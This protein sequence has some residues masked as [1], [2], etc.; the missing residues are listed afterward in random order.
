MKIFYTI[1]LL[2]STTLSVIAQKALVPYRVGKL[3]GLSDEK[4]NI[5][6]APAYDQ[7]YWLSGSWFRAGKKIELKDTLE[8]AP[9][10]F[11]IRNNPVTV[12]SLMYNGKMVLKDEPFDDVELIAGK[13]IAAKYEGRGTDLTKENFKKYGNTRKFYSLFNLEGK[14]LHPENF[15]SIRKMDTTGVSTRYKNQ[16]RYILFWVISL[17]NKQGLLV[18]DADRQ[19]ISE[20]LV[21]DAHQMEPDR[22]RTTPGQ[23]LLYVTDSNGVS[24]QQMLDYREGK[25]VLQPAPSAMYPG[26]TRKENVNGREIYAGSGSGNG[27]GRMDIETV[28]AEPG[29]EDRPPRPAPKFKPYHTF[30]R[31]S[32]YY[33]TS[34]QRQVPVQLP[35][36]ARIIRMV[37][38]AMTQYQ[39]V[40]VI[41]DN[42]F[43]MVKDDQ[44]GTVAYDSL[45][46]F[47]QHFLA[48][49]KVD[50][51][52]KAG[53]INASDS[54]I[55]PFLYDSLYA[56]IRYLELID[57]NPAALT[58]DYRM[59]YKEA[60][61]KY[62]RDKVNP[63]VRTPANL[64]T[65]FIKDQCG[66]VNFKNETV[67]P[68]KYQVIAKNSMG[69]S[70]PREDE[71]IIL[72]SNGHYGLTT[73][74]YDREKLQDGMTNTIEPIFDYL[75]GFFYPRYYG[76]QNFR[77]VGLYNEQKIFMGYATDNGKTFYRE[78]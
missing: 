4:G 73:L 54:V 67:I 70:R 9:G 48:W 30:M 57:K 42:S 12:M 62:S 21:K 29:G 11:H 68:F 45:I 49:K 56:G 40:I 36:A 55:L 44:L 64:L 58:P 31:D 7:L 15:K 19:E 72:K 51:K 46:Y 75:P 20:W 78:K 13:C 16:G 52:I 6:L 63:Y 35:A 76:I 74:K 34:Y 2:L 53:V 28:V 10:K 33:V 18:F 23:L 5:V 8:T 65:V 27:T 3:F 38:Y 22:K 39:P 77:L 37:P 41:A 14:N 69:H 1:V 17:S 66:V 71:F 50:G 47:G 59:V 26:A 60:D 24:S 43:Y 32:L 25:F 61:S